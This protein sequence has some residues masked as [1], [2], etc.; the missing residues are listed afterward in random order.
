MLTLSAVAL[1]CAAAFLPKSILAQQSGEPV[2]HSETHLIDFT[3]SVS[4]PD[5]VLVSNLGR[6]DFQI[7]EDGVAQKIAFFGK[8]AELPLTLGL[9]VDASDSQSKFIKRHRKDIRSFLTTVIRPHDEAFS[10]CFGN[11]LRL[12]ND[13]S[14]SIDAI[15]DGLDRFDHGDRNFPELAAED[16]REDQSGGGTA[17]YDA[18]YYSVNQRL[19]QAEG[20]R[21][22][23]IVFSDGE[24]NA[25]AHDLI[26]AIDAARS[27]DTL[28]YAVRYTNEKERHTPHARQGVAVMHHLSS[29]TGGADF[30]ALHTDVKQAFAQI[31]EDLRSLYSVAY[32]STNTRRDGTFRR[33]IITTSD[34]SY[35]IR[36]R[37]GYYAR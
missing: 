14:S 33:V 35:T 6:E 34:P 31:A 3:F 15:I 8:E 9:I 36:A 21:R 37:T 22:A 27:N 32:H 1:V 24:E 19:T 28:I 4:R 30:D 12:T 5:G 16:K 17:L 20:R 2:F 23:L 26:E 7:T 10:L 13:S 18:I 25:S 11:H 29:E